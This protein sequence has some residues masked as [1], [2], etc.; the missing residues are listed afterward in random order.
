M[1]IIDM[2]N[3]PRRSQFEFF[4]AMDYP[5][6]NVC[7]DVD[8]TAVRKLAK[9]R[10]LKFFNLILYFSSRA[11][12]RIPE[13]KTRIRDGRVVEHETVHPS[14]TVM[15]ENNVFNFC[16]AE[17]TC[18]P[19]AFFRK[20]DENTRE[21]KL[22]DHLV[23]DDRDDLLYITSLPW[24]SFTSLQHPV[25][26]NRNDSVP[27]LSW[28][29]FTR[30]DGRWWMPYSFQVHHGLADGFHAGFF[31]EIFQEMLLAPESHIAV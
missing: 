12:N 21:V 6:F 15:G 31:Y 8:I 29:R 5:H 14:F 30:K 9:D 7:F 2:N 17:F 4:S 13:M 27:R 19:P 22:S 18:D 28:G 10:D 3:W 26:M 20:V 25:N 11:A 1:K 23:H 24:I 16:C